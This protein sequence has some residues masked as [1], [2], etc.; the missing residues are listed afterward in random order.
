MGGTKDGEVADQPL[1]LMFALAEK[2]S[3]L[4]LP[5]AATRVSWVAQ[6]RELGERIF[7]HH[8]DFL[9]LC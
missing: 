9:V 5:A 7:V 3:L 8:Q 2:R 1:H 4:G 6:E